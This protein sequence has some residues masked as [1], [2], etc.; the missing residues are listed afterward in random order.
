LCFNTVVSARDTEHRC[1]Q[2][3]EGKKR[4]IPVGLDLPKRKT[5]LND[6]R[7]RPERKE[8]PSAPRR[9]TLDQPGQKKLL[10][11]KRTYPKGKKKEY[12]KEENAKEENS[13]GG[14]PMSHRACDKEGWEERR[15]QRKRASA[16]KET[17]HWSGLKDCAL[18]HE[19]QK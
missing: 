14:I 8:G 15:V 16:R 11:E 18:I 6:V 3:Q 9:P 4:R 5:T 13:T 19:V 2:S 17:N 7:E 10:E 1:A 12:L